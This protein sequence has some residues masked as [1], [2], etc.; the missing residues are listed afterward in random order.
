[1]SSEFKALVAVVLLA[2]V[3]SLGKAL[4]HMSSSPEQSEQTVRA[5]TV[6]IGL[7]IALF[8]L[9]LGAWHFGLISPHELRR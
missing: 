1:M 6:R 4:F 8:L 5:L 7:S 9:L 2:I 3:A